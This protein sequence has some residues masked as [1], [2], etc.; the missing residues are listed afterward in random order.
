MVGDV[1]TPIEQEQKSTL[2]I[3]LIN[4]FLPDV[5]VYDVCIV[6]TSKWINKPN[7]T[8]TYISVCSVVVPGNK[9]MVEA[10]A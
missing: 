2:G 6:N 3:Q 4:I 1:F 9:P 7:K 10:A 5:Y 8:I